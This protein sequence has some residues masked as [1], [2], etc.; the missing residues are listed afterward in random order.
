MRDKDIEITK[1]EGGDTITFKAT[2]PKLSD[3]AELVLA[4]ISDNLYNAHHTGVPKSMGG[5]GVGTALV[6]AMSE[7]ARDLGYKIVPGCPFVAAWFKREPKWAK[8]A[9]AEPDLFLK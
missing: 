1:E 4:Q 8:M 2:V 3:E 5:M 9:A 7:D 6:K